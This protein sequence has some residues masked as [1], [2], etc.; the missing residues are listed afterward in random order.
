MAFLP[1]TGASTKIFDFLGGLCSPSVGELD[2]RFRDA[3]GEIGFSTFASVSDTCS[4]E[5][6]G[7]S[8]SSLGTAPL[9]VIPFGC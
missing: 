1:G 8:D 4:T 3:S 5:A 6:I 9:S 7:F 2:L